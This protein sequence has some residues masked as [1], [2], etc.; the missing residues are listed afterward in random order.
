MHILT[1]IIEN[2][3][4]S[5]YSNGFLEG[6]NNRLKMIKRVFS[7]LPLQPQTGKAGLDSSD[8]LYLILHGMRK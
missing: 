1:G 4:M 2:S 7:F 5:D 8:S 3:V 6:N